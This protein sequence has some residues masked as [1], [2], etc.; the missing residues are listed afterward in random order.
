M[1]DDELEVAMSTI[2]HSI[3]HRL[4][5]CECSSDDESVPDPLVGI[6]DDLHRSGRRHAQRICACFTVEENRSDG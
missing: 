1:G 5:L 2:V 6:F 3:T 4:Q